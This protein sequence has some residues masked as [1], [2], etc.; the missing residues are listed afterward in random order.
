MKMSRAMTFSWMWLGV[1]L[2]HLLLTDSDLG[3]YSGLVNA[4]V[5][6]AADWINVNGN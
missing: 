1:G 2:L 5:W 3:F 6:S 4:T